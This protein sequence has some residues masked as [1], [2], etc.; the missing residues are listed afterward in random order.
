[1]SCGSTIVLNVSTL[2]MMNVSQENL[3]ISIT[4]SKVG[5]A[6]SDIVAEAWASASK[7]QALYL[8]H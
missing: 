6:A 8:S 1:M 5:S 2:C 4:K 7:H 3:F